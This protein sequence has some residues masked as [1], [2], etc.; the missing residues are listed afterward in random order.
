MSK[1]VKKNDTTCTFR[2]P[3]KLLVELDRWAW[4]RRLQRSEVVRK[5]IKRYMA[6]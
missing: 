1:G 2:L 5:A 4:K 6:A 3:S